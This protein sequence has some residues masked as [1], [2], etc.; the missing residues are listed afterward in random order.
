M[1]SVWAV[2]TL[3]WWLEVVVE[4][5]GAQLLVWVAV[6]W[7]SCLLGPITTAMGIQVSGA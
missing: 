6:P 4:F 7:H 3:L 1:S 2:C 5:F